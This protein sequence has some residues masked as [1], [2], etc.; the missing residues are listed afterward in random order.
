M[1][2]IL[3]WT[4]PDWVHFIRL[5]FCEGGDVALPFSK[6]RSRGDFLTPNLDKEVPRWHSGWKG[7]SQEAA[8]FD[9]AV[10]IFF[11][12]S[13]F[14]LEFTQATL[15]R[16]PW[17][18]FATGNMLHIMLWQSKMMTAWGIHQ[19][20][21]IGIDDFWSPDLEDYSHW[22]RTPCRM[23]TK[24]IAA[25]LGKHLLNSE[26]ANHMSCG[27]LS[28]QKQTATQEKT[29]MSTGKTTGTSDNWSIQPFRSGNHSKS[30]LFFNV[31]FWWTCAGHLRKSRPSLRV[32]HQSQDLLHG[33]EIFGTISSSTTWAIQKIN[34]NKLNL[35]RILVGHPGW[36]NYACFSCC[37]V[38]LRFPNNQASQAFHPS[39]R[40]KSLVF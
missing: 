14:D 4:E 40:P 26:N 18:L 8:S 29:Q 7:S 12:E 31:H 13:C 35:C 33:L 38:K 25:S 11:F 30:Q 19:C 24:R 2:G 15:W 36:L 22:L 1:T 10:F 9:V 34:I 27:F 37:F 17:W 20:I 39:V 21:S 6:R 28:I 3:P 5:W 23:N 16:G 32:V